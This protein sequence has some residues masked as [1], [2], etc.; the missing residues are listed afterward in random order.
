[1]FAEVAELFMD[2]DAQLANILNYENWL[3]KLPYL[4][5]VLGKINEKYQFLQNQT[6]VTVL[7]A[8]TKVSSFKRLFI[9]WLDYVSKENIIAFKVLKRFMN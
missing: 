4:E 2:H 5:Y 8:A 1:M 6:T 9:Y 7:K 3:W